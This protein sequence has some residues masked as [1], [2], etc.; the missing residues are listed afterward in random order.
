VLAPNRDLASSEQDQLDSDLAA[1][2]FDS[3]AI[4][5]RY[6]G[7]ALIIESERDEVIP[8]STIVAYL[9]ACPGAQHQIIKCATHALTD[10]TWDE[11][12]VK[13]IVDWFRHL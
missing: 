2:G 5:Q 10:P 8:P 6:A 1:G 13:A 3:L 11:V 9:C 12:F 4:L 7:D